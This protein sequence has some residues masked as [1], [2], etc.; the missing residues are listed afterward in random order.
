MVERE[1]ELPAAVE[2]AEAMLSEH[3]T[4]YQELRDRLPCFG[5]AI[6]TQLSK[7]LDAIT[8]SIQGIAI[9][10]YMSPSTCF[11][12]ISCDIYWVLMTI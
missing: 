10:Y 3:T 6:D 12:I 9:W 4:K 5:E 7:Y 11:Q 8:S 2:L 1:V